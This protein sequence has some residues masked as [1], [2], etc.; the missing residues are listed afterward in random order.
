MLLVERCLLR[1]EG[2]AAAE[3]AADSPEVPVM[4]RIA[5]LAFHRD[6]NNEYFKQLVG[7]LKP[8]GV[9]VFVYHRHDK[10]RHLVT[11][12]QKGFYIGPGSSPSMNRVFLK[13]GGTGAVKQ[14]RHVLVPPA[15]AQQHA[16]RMH[17]AAKRYPPAAYEKGIHEDP[18]CHVATQSCATAVPG[19]N[20]HRDRHV[21]VFSQAADNNVQDSIKVFPNTKEAP[22][23]SRFAKAT[24]W[25]IDASSATHFF[26][27]WGSTPPARDGRRENFGYGRGGCA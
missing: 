22:R 8:W 15:F 25:P 2:D 21:L 19:S 16:M 11:R 7:Q 26:R 27:C 23:T 10:M 6:V 20:R 4:D 18:T 24:R 14:F 12:R 9:P 3:A 5:Y 1:G 17:Q 13:D